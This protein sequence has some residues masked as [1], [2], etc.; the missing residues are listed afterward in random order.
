[1]LLT[2]SDGALRKVLSLGRNRQRLFLSDGNVIFFSCPL[3]SHWQ[4]LWLPTPKQS[5]TGNNN[6]RCSYL[7]RS[8]LLLLKIGPRWLRNIREKNGWWANALMMSQLQWCLCWRKFKWFLRSCSIN[9]RNNMRCLRLNKENS[10]DFLAMEG[11]VEF[12]M[13]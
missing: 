12:F 10:C 1:M 11:I 7:D 4:S 3:N 13:M 5:V 9:A 8:L 2:R 6:S